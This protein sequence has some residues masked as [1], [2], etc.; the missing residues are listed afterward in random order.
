MTAFSS[1]RYAVIYN[2]LNTLT[3]R[4]LNNFP[5][6]LAPEDVR[7]MVI[8]PEH[9]ELA[10]QAN[11][12]FNPDNRTQEYSINI[13]VP[14]HYGN[15]DVTLRNENGHRFLLPPYLKGSASYTPEACPTLNKIENWLKERIRQGLEWGL[16]RDV[17]DYLNDVCETPQQL[18][19]YFPGIITLMMNTKDDA[20]M[21]LAN[22][23]RAAR[24]PTNY[25]TMTP[26]M[27]EALA[28]ANATLALVQLIGA[29]REAQHDCQALLGYQV[30]NSIKVPSPLPSREWTTVV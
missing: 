4:F 24:I 5:C 12:L 22:N 8:K 6:P 15:V 18:R 28:Q 3:H 20:I 16:V 9:R 13:L 26:A 2:A 21:K 11:A 7:R 25:I 10:E 30:N 17:L 29:P 19:F 23:I 14:T 1:K 27:K